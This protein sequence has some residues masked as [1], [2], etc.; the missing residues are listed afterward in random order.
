MAKSEVV[1]GLD[2][3][4]A[5]VTCVIGAP[6]PEGQG[7]KVLG[8]ASVPCVGVKGGV[9]INIQDAARSIRQAVEKA[10][11]QAGADVDSVYLGVR[12]THIESFNNR[13]AYNIARSDK[14]ITS[15]DVAAVIENAKAIP[16]S[17]DREILHVIP[18][19]FGLDRQRGVPD[20]VGMEGSLLE[21]EVHIVTASSN[22]LNNLNRAASEAGF[23]VIEPIYSPLAL[24]EF[25]V[26]LEERDLGSLLI[27]LGG[28]TISVVVYS[29]GSVRF[30]RELAPGTDAITR[31]MAIGL[32]THMPTAER[33]KIEHGVA[34]PALV[35]GGGET[36]ISFKGLDGRSEKQVRL[37]VLTE[38]ILPRVEEIL[39]IV[40]T[41]V[42]GSNYADVVLPCGSILT[43]GGA[44]M[45]GFPEAAKQVLNMSARLGLPHDGIVQA[46]ENLLDSAFST[47]L[48][49]VCYPQ[50]TMHRASGL[51]RKTPA[52][53]MLRSLKRFF[54]DF[55]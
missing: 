6:D 33:I 38:I 50:S 9:V 44:M 49:L 53:G 47:A 28:Q 19:G 20:P 3:G 26:T 10:E 7:M 41:A 55:M 14:E 42:Q 43:G 37:Q 25:L 48:A 35:N 12:G 34:H 18:Q 11:A 52:S 24:G 46:P 16:I 23:K 27:D 17:N 40:G 22:H 4:S 32:Q 8:G 13:G 51:A 21:V 1:A 31:D 30:T 15:E 5:R 54:K 29:E 45:K 2:M 39:T 36:L